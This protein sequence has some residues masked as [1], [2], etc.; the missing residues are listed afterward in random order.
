MTEYSPAKT[1][2]YSRIFPSFENSARCEKR[3]Q[4]FTEVEV[5][6]AGCKY[7]TLAADTEVNSCFSMMMQTATPIFPSCSEV[8]SAGYSEFD[9]PISAR[10]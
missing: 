1:V 8:N 2:E 7:P 10:V 4:L 3:K 9:E 6:S 5:A